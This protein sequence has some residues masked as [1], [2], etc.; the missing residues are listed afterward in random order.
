MHIAR[1]VN[2]KEIENARMSIERLKNEIQNRCKYVRKKSL[3]K[4]KEK[5]TLVMH[6]LL[7]FFE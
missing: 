2:A 1:L 7:D 3:K 5:I 4:F 6:L